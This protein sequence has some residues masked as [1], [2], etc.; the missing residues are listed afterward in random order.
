V[1]LSSGVDLAK[2]LSLSEIYLKFCWLTIE[3]FSLP[4]FSLMILYPPT[5][6]LNSLPSI[7]ALSY[8]SSASVMIPALLAHSIAV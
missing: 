8:L 3:Y 2:T 7:Q 4:S 1:N 5:N 6:S